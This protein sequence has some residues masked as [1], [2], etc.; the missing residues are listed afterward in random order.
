MSEVLRNQIPTDPTATLAA[1]PGAAGVSWSL[2]AGHGA[3]FPSVGNFRLRCDSEIVLCT[4]RSTD[5]LTVTRAQE[6][7]TGAAHAIGAAVDLVLTAESLRQAAR[8]VPLEAF[9]RHFDDCWHISRT[10]WG[11]TVSGGSLLGGTTVVE[12]PG[13]WILR[14]GGAAGNYAQIYLGSSA[15][16]GASYGTDLWDVEYLLLVPPTPANIDIFA[17]M[18]WT[19]GTTAEPSR[20]VWFRKLAADANWQIV[21]KGAAS[22]ID[23]SAVAASASTWYRLRLWYDGTNVK[24]SINGSAEAT[25]SSMANYDS[26]RA[27]V[28][29]VHTVFSVTASQDVT[30]D[31]L[32]VKVAGLVR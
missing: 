5:T 28:A 1:D 4:A 9:T 20:G 27:Y 12:H 14:S 17:G 25:I 16:Q 10:D 7:T 22:T 26:A 6:G 29:F 13:I 15:S 23:N 19:L 18:G 24:W 30:I 2:T 8:E 11:S 3:R 21:V 32:D 31:S